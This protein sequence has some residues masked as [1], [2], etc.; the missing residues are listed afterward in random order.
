MLQMAHNITLGSRQND[1]QFFHSVGPTTDMIYLHRSS[2]PS[3]EIICQS[4]NDFVGRKVV[5]INWSTSS[6]PERDTYEWS[7]P[8]QFS[9]SAKGKTLART[10]SPTS[11]LQYLHRSSESS[12][13]IVVSYVMMFVQRVVLWLPFS[14]LPRFHAKTLAQRRAQTE[15]WNTHHEQKDSPLTFDALCPTARHAIGKSGA[16]SISCAG[17]TRSMKHQSRCSTAAIKQHTTCPNIPTRRYA[18]WNRDGG[19]WRIVDFFKK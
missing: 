13:Q 12:R 7:I 15:T 4:T 9:E 18:C 1:R 3:S 19:G 17:Q 11:D 5:S 14:C 16:S 8:V 6:F 10:F 2:E